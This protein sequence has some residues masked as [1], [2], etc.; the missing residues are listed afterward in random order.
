M[1]EGSV[2]VCVCRVT[3][4]EPSFHHAPTRSKLKQSVTSKYLAHLAP[5]YNPSLTA[6]RVNSRNQPASGSWGAASSPRRSP[7]HATAADN[8]GF[9]RLSTTL[10]H[11][12]TNGLKVSVGSLGDYNSG[13]GG[14]HGGNGSMGGLA[15]SH[16]GLNSTFVT[17]Q[18]LRVAV[19]HWV[20]T[21]SGGG[22]GGGASGGGGGG[23]SGVHNYGPESPQH[24]HSPGQQSRL[25][26]T[27]PANSNSK[28]LSEGGHHTTLLVDVGAEQGSPRRAEENSSPMRK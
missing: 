19:P 7:S 5:L 27:Y 26:I 3:P 16:G 9:S 18:G 22:S 17:G 25:A 14:A 1:E 6:L 13:G 28:V 8:I 4:G 24:V 15:G 23:S 21:G 11:P 2:R 10:D 20:D 12:H